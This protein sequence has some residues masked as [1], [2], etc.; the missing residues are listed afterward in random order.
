MLLSP[1]RRR[2]VR[3]SSQRK[4]ASPADPS[5]SQTVR[6]L[7]A[8]DESAFNAL[9]NRH[10]PS[11]IRVACLYVGSRAIAE[12]VVQETWIDMIGGLESFEE[13]SSLRTWIFVILINNARKRAEREARSIP[14]SHL[15]QELGEPAPEDGLFFSPDHPRW[16]GAWTTAVRRWDALPHE[17]LITRETFDVVLRAAE[18]L[19]PLQRTVLTLRDV[20]GLAPADVCSM[21]EISEGNQRVL[22]HRARG[23]VRIALERYLEGRI[24]C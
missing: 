9:I 11:M 12:E 4:I 19:P 22:L 18:D 21:L 16:P 2:S 8:G 10:G 15:E 13:R 5:E 6:A 23:R 20:E 24:R 7:R 14:V 1:P 17:T 3:I